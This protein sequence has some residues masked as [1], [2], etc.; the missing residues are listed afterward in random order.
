MTAVEQAHVVA[1]I[2]RWLRSEDPE[3]A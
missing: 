3:A 1:A 2:A